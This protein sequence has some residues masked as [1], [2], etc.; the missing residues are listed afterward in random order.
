MTA[1]VV[2]V[3]LFWS[4]CAS[5]SV[6]VRRE[7]AFL[8]TYLFHAGSV[9]LFVALGS[10]AGGVLVR[11]GH[12]LFTVPAFALT[13]IIGVLLGLRYWSFLLGDVVD[14]VR[15]SALGIDRMK[16]E[17]T[18]DLAEKAAHEGDDGAAQRLYEEAAAR[19]PGDPEARRRI[20]EIHLRR[21]RTAEAVEALRSALA[22]IGEPE[23]RAT[24]AFRISDLLAGA[25]RMEE[26]RALLGSIA[27]EVAGTRLEAYARERLAGLPPPDAF[28]AK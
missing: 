9:T 21:G 19:D 7:Y 10:L 12:P 3:V 28:T 26:A 13:V 5:L 18:Y 20:A 16:V 25:G 24:L 8:Q 23:P 6:L 17:R 2:C 27:R 14:R 1:A 15:A 11:A 22:L 4:Y